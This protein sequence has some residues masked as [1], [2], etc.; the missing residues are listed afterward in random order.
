MNE[1]ELLEFIRTSIRSVWTVELLLHLLRSA[2]R[3]WTA[4]ELVREMRASDIIVG[5]GLTTLLTAGLVSSD[6]SGNFRY[7]P[8][9]SSLD[10]LVQQLAVLHR[11]R[12][13]AVTKA[14]YSRPN[15][16]LQTLADAFRFKKD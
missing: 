1:G 5:E 3:T 11:D 2:H 7:A 4:E 9:S 12:P 10:N 6:A 13:S 15:E 14:I 16:K 8:A